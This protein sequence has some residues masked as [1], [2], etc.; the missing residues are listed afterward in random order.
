MCF[1]HY[2]D[3]FSQAFWNAWHLEMEKNQKKKKKK[4]LKK[5]KAAFLS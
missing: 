5:N 4:K 1:C 2:V 3:F